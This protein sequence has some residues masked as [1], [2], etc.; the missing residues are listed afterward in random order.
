MLD[1]TLA[2]DLDIEFT[3][4]SYNTRVDRMAVIFPFDPAIYAGMSLE[5]D[6][7]GHPLVD[8]IVAVSTEIDRRRARAMIGV[9][10]NAKLVSLFP[11]SRSNEI[12]GQLPVQLAAALRLHAC[13]PV[14]QFALAV[15]PSVHRGRIDEIVRRAQLPASLRLLVVE[16][17]SREVMLAGDVALAKP[18]TVTVELALLGRPMVVMGRTS[19]LTAA[20][21]RRAI[22]LPSLTMPNLIAGEAIV[23]EFLQDEADPETIARA[24][25]GLFAG[26]ERERQLKALEEVRRQLGKGGSADRAGRIAEEMIAPSHP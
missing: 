23:P 1:L 20:I 17:C 8:K 2:D 3:M 19:A 4:S 18:G 12:R 14:I 6:Y 26:P 22:K 9:E 10:E 15:A 25:L 11:G 24:I 16:N 21:L 7:G 5:V 13:D